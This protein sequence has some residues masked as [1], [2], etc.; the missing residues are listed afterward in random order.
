MENLSSHI[1]EPSVAV[2]LSG[3]VTDAK[4]LL[5]Q[6]VAML[7]LDAR[8]ELRQAKSAAITRGI[9]IGIV[10]AGG[11]LLSVMLVQMLAV[12]LE[13][14]LWGCYGIVGSSLVVLGGVWL[15]LGTTTT[16]DLT[17]A[18]RPTMKPQK[19]NGQ[20]LTKQRTSNKLL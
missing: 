15:A 20:W 17:V 7:K 12:F 3:I 13:L 19:E 8:E 6:E 1:A 9:G 4:N 5:E 14:P 16:A 11:V 2:L 10:A 18:T